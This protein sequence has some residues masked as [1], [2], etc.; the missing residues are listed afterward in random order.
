MNL[1]LSTIKRSSGHTLLEMALSLVLLSTV[2]A[3]VG[4]AVMFASSVAPDEDSVEQTLAQDSRVLSQIAEDIAQAR[5]VIEQGANAITIVVADRTGDGNPDRV[6][7]AWSGKE[8]DTLTYQLNDD[9]AVSLIDEVSTFSLAYTQKQS[10]ETLPNAIYFADESLIDGFTETG[11]VSEKPIKYSEWYG[12]VVNPSLESNASGFVPTRLL[13]YA[14]GKSPYT[15]Q[16]LLELKGRSGATPGT[17]TFASQTINESDLNWQNI[18]RQYD[19]SDALFVDGGE[20]LGFY[21]SYVSGQNEV[22]NINE[23]SSNRSTGKIQSK[24]RGSTWELEND[25]AFVYQLYGK[26][27]LTSTGRYET[28]QQHV[29][30]IDIRLQSFVVDRSPLSRRVRMLLAPPVLSGFAATGFDSDPS[31]VDLNADGEPDWSHSAGTFPADSVSGGLWAC[32][33]QLIYNNKSLV[34]AEV[35]TVRA[36]MRSNDTLGP[37]IYGPYTFDDKAQLLPLITQLRSDGRGGQELV[38]YN[39]TKMSEEKLKLTDLPSGLVDIE[40]TLVPALDMVSVSINHW[41]VGSYL[42]D[43][44]TD[45]SV[46][47]S[48]VR[49]GSTG[50]VA[51]FGSIYISVGGGYQKQADGGSAA[52]TTDDYE[53][54]LNK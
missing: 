22:L 6:R 25:K 35:I 10:V 26:Q 27:K 20:D 29:S 45:S 15:G 30:V 14:S 13:L 47:E 37:A 4:S 21:I 1:K 53:L 54:I 33:G 18:W 12:Q 38:I 44:V 41:L 19:L 5:Y 7:Y 42:L 31:G 2:A 11:S 39:D 24:D 46:V 36:R 48:A 32:N 40:L 8:G 43:R 23:A 9:N 50:G 16:T 17:T 49:F 28:T 34:T 3:S 51:E 52:V